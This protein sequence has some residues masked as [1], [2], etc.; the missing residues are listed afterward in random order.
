MGNKQNDLRITYTK[1]VIKKALFELMEAQPIGDIT[2]TDICKGAGINRGTFYKYYTDPLDLLKQI[3]NELFAEIQNVLKKSLVTGSN[4]EFLIKILEYTADNSALCSILFSSNGD[5]EFIQQILN[6]AHDK[7]ILEYKVS[8]PDASE[9]SLE[10]L[11]I[12]IANGIIG[13][14]QD[15]IQSGLDQTPEEVARFISN[16]SNECI[17]SFNNGK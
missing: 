7:S 15:W 13:I 6:L 11:F 9:K 14:I 8:A 17:R 4:F 1:T 2:V 16:L 5:K 12:F 3:E 10:R